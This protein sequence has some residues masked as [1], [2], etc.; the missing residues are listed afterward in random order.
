MPRTSESVTQKEREASRQRMLG[1]TIWL[2]R[3]K[4]TE[5]IRKNAEARKNPARQEALRTG[6][7]H[8][9]TGKP[10][11]HGHVA[12][13][14]TKDG[15]CIKCG[16]EKNQQAPHKKLFMAARYRA[17][18][19]GCPF[20]ITADDVLA[21]WPVDNRC[22]IFGTV[23]QRDRRSV[24][25]HGRGATLD[26]VIPEQGYV[27]GNIAILSRRANAVKQDCT[28]PNVFHRLG[29]WLTEFVSRANR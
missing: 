20:D 21:I 13:R 15:G 6:Q 8:Y 29:N 2:G 17:T 23:F 19:E 4:S 14:F 24:T 26:K 16:E 1:N 27:R 3:K 11:K 5:H 9:F 12:E 22:P 7:P 10:C 28:D 18:Q 25:K